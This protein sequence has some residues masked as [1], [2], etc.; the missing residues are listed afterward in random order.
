M[1]SVVGLASDVDVYGSNISRLSTFMDSW[2]RAWPGL[3]IEHQHAF[4]NHH[5]MMGFGCAAGHYLAL[6]D[7]LRYLRTRNE[8]CDYP[9]MFE[10]DALPFARRTWPAAAHAPVNDLDAR[11]DH[12]DA[13][14]GTVLVLGGHTFE[15]YSK[16]DAEAAF[17]RRQR[18]IVNVGHVDGSFAYV[19][20]CKAMDAV[21]KGLHKLLRQPRREL[22]FEKELWDIFASLPDNGAADEVGVHV[23]IPLLVD[24]A[25]G[26]SATWNE[27]V[28]RPQEG[29]AVFW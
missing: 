4:I 29:S 6:A 23:S 18:G 7:S 3:H 5:T 17:R 11:L 9:L 13:I 14:N 10:D 26:F 1:A 16:F 25:R 28:I 8:T 22:W 19:F 24:H 20:K 2:A 12:L 21:A 15:N 27:I